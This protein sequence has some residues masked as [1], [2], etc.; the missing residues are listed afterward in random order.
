MADNVR[1]S[2][3]IRRDTEDPIYATIGSLLEAARVDAGMTMRQVGDALGLH[4]T[5][6]YYYEVARNRIPL[7]VFVRWCEVLEQNP[8]VLLQR[9]KEGQK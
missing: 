2:E 8:G 3:S 1:R 4:V 7:G 5:T 6:V 9:A